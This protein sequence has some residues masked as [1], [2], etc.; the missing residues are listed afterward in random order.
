MEK[1]LINRY[2]FTNR[3][4]LILLE[5]YLLNIVIESAFSNIEASTI[6]RVTSL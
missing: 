1:T 6:F 4:C 5:I 3:I 2:K